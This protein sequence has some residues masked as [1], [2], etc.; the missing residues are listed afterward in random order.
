MEIGDRI[1]NLER[2]RII[3]NKNSESKIIKEDFPTFIHFWSY[4]CQICKQTL[5]EINLLRELFENNINIVSIHMPRSEEEL[6]VNVVKEQIKLNQIK[7]TTIID[8]QYTVADAFQNK[9]VPAFY[10]FDKDGI[11]IDF[12]AGELNIPNLDNVIKELLK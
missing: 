3:V 8:N 11:L 5:S 2:N 1:P 10:L 4:S 7:H 9:F 12:Q 6:Q